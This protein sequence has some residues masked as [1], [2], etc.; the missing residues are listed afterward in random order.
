MKKE[1][2]VMAIMG[3]LGLVLSS[4]EL[5]SSLSDN[6][7]SSKNKI[8]ADGF[9]MTINAPKAVLTTGQILDIQ[10]K[11]SWLEE[12]TSG[13]LVR[14]DLTCSPS[15]TYDPTGIVEITKEDASKLKALTLGVS[16]VTA[17][18]TGYN[19]TSDFIWAVVNPIPSETNTPNDTFALAN[20]ITSI[21][22]GTIDGSDQ[23]YWK[24]DVPANNTYRVVL[25]NSVDLNPSS[26]NLSASYT[27][28]F[29]DNAEKSIAPTALN[30]LEGPKVANAQTIFVRVTS[31]KTQNDTPYQVKLELFP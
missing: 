1:L 20:P 13:S 2:K 21:V 30:R 19:N 24:F 10:L 29:F 18:V 9:Q 28:Q 27:A 12:N 14:K 4:C 26:G 7:C 22:T 8:S 6:S 5:L 16:K 17:N 3:V 25:S 11:R 23:D 31:S 15:W